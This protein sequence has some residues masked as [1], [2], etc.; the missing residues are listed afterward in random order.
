M[1]TNTGELRKFQE[2]Q[3]DLIDP[4]Q[5]VDMDQ[6]T[7]KQ[8]QEMKVSLRDH[9]STLGKLLTARRYRTLRRKWLLR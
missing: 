3:K 8:K 7:D 6:A 4:W 1:N 2:A 5:P 9:R